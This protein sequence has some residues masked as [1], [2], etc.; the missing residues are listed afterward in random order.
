MYKVKHLSCK[1]LCYAQSSACQHVEQID[2]YSMK[3]LVNIYI[4]EDDVITKVWEDKNA[5]VNGARI[6]LGKLTTTADANYK[7]TTMKFGTGGHVTGDI[8][9]P[10]E[11]S[12]A[13]SNLE[14]VVFSKTIATW[15]YEPTG[16]ETSVRFQVTMEKTQANGSGTT[17]YTE[18]GLF[19][20]N[21]TLFA[22]ETF[23]A[24]VKTE[25]RRIIFD[26]T[27]LF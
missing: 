1:K 14:T 27:I 16:V 23:P 9:T 19:C 17:A 12:L 3:G 24:I 4:D 22:R 8:L 20:A 10:I 15:Y 26:W 11:P 5:I 2:K 7:I 18:A 21:G 6:A 25:N 13:D